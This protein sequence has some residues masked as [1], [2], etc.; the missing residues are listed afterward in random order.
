MTAKPIRNPGRGVRLGL[1]A[2]W[3]CVGAAV[4]G[5]AVAG[6]AGAAPPPALS[7]GLGRMEDV[8]V[9]HVLYGASD[10]LGAERAQLWRQGEG[11]VAEVAEYWDRFGMALAAGDYNGDGYADLAIGAPHEGLGMLRNVGVVHVLYGSADGLR[12][13]GSQLWQQGAGGLLGVGEDG[14]QFGA[15]L[16][17]GDLNGDGRADLA[18]AIP[19]KT[20]DG[21]AKAGAVAVLY[22]SAGGLTA[23][24]NQVWHQNSPGVADAPEA[25]DSLGQALSIGDWNRDGRA[26]LAI[27]V[28]NED[29]GAVRDAGVVHIVFGSPAGLTSV[30]SQLWSQDSPGVE[31]AAEA[32][33]R[34]GA[35]LASGAVN[36]STYPD[37]AIGVPDQTVGGLQAAGAVQMLFGSSAGLTAAGSQFWH[38]DAIGAPDK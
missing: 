11:G 15:V 26:D 28:P 17:A 33:E 1:C 2:L 5:T 4:A 37:L 16:A 7:Q 12:A 8:G 19:N 31:D 3:A 20:V 34:F 14:D 38:Q 23:A 21:A 27:G 35:A 29:L 13:A 10:G 25:N 32:D 24:G 36:G 9:V 30:G 22:G 18:I 6:D